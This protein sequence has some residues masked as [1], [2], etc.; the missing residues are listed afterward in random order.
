MKAESTK[1]T[2]KVAVAAVGLAAT[3]TLPTG[4]ATSAAGSAGLVNTGGSTCIGPICI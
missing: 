2:L 1:K 3:L 4:C